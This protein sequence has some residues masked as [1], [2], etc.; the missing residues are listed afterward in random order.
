MPATTIQ[1]DIYIA[2]I[3]LAEPVI[4]GTGLLIFSFCMYAWH[5]LRRRNPAI[6]PVRLIRLFFLFLA[7]SALTG[8]FFGHLFSYWA[9]IFG[10]AVCWTFSIT[11]FAILAQAAIVHARPFLS[12]W[13]V[14][15]LTTLNGL[16]VIGA[17]ELTSFHQSYYSVEVHCAFALF[18]L[19]MPL[20]IL[21]FSKRRDPGSRMLLWAVPLSIIAVI[22]HLLQWS[23]SVWFTAADVSHVLVLGSLWA[24]LMGG[25]RL[26]GYTGISR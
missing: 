15:V 5:R 25:E 19:I 24:I 7:A 2:G 12:L 22:P 14:R 23:P 21:I 13:S 8:A 1:P 11:S 3:R 9:G 17:I 10:K 20:E 6:L 26:R 4:A 18:F 16:S